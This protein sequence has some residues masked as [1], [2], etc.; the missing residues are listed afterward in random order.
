VKRKSKVAVSIFI[1]DD[2]PGVR[3][4]LEFLFEV[5][6]LDARGF[7]SGSEFMGG[8]KPGDEDCI[9]LDVQMPGMSGFDVLR[10]LRRQGSASPVIMTTGLPSPD[11]TKRAYQHGAFRVLDKPYDSSALLCAV[12]E[13]LGEAHGSALR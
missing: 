13:A 9:I 7:A 4:S 6:G 12:H 11:T 1:V 8:G 10:Q 3:E 5:E 2:D